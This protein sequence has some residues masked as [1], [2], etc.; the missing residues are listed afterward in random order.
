M[1]IFSIIILVVGL[2][3]SVSYHKDANGTDFNFKLNLND[4]CCKTSWDLYELQV[5]YW[6]QK[7][8]GDKWWMRPLILGRSDSLLTNESALPLVVKLVGHLFFLRILMPTKYSP[9][10]F[11]GNPPDKLFARREDFYLHPFITSKEHASA[12][13]P[14]EHQYGVPMV[15]KWRTLKSILIYSLHLVINATQD[16]CFGK[17]FVQYMYHIVFH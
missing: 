1:V 2:S 8:Q 16:I 15:I 12:L 9:N 17:K 6:D 5:Y 7:E 13:Q 11:V 4:W 3:L 10:R 14:I